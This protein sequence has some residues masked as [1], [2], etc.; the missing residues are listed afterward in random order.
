MISK[1]QAIDSYPTNGGIIGYLEVSVHRQISFAS[2]HW[3]S[4]IAEH[5]WGYTKTSRG[6]REYRVQHPLEVASLR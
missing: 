5:Y 4:F 3:S 2:G 1:R 6:T